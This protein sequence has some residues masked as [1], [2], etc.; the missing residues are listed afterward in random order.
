MMMSSKTLENTDLLGDAVEV[1]VK[2]HES[3]RFDLET[4][5]SK[6]QMLEHLNTHGYAVV[7][8]VV[9]PE[10]IE[11]CKG[12]F[13]DYLEERT[14]ARRSDVKTWHGGA[15]LPDEAFGLMSHGQFNQSEYMWTLRMLP[16]VKTAFQSIWEGNDDLLVS[17]D[18]GNAFR[19]WKF[20]PTWITEGGWWHVDQGLAKKGK[21]V[22]VQGLINLYDATAQTGGLCVLPGSHKLHGTLCER[23]PDIEK[24]EDFCKIPKTDGVLLNCAEA[25]MVGC[26][27][28]DLIV[29]DSRTIHC[30]SPALDLDEDNDSKVDGQWDLIRLVGY[31][32]MTPAAMANETTLKRRKEVFIRSGSTN[33]WPHECHILGLAPKRVPDKNWD[34]TPQELRDLVVG[35]QQS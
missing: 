28:G 18:G 20:N 25:I 4:D 31:V 26:K 19:P 17:F 13:W 1:P 16:K 33:H 15:W 35:K 10:T 12:L 22:C 6:Q 14:S 5:E 7:A 24:L 3:Q 9:P 29:W 21:K 2:Y 27:A 8:G 23:I 30:N 32:C 11:K 34:E